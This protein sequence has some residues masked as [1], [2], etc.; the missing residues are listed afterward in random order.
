MRGPRRR[1]DG[2]PVGAAEAWATW[3]SEVANGDRLVA[4]IEDLALPAA[5]TSRGA[6]VLR[7]ILVHLIEEYARHNGYADLLREA[8]DG[9]TGE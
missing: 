5:S 4:T 8:I 9:R 7:E 2:P 1:A 3:R 6:L